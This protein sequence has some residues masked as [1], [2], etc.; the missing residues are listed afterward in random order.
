MMEVSLIEGRP[1]TKPFGSVPRHITG[2]PLPRKWRRPGVLDADWSLEKL[3][4]FWGANLVITL[5]QPNIICYHMLLFLVTCPTNFH[6]MYNS[7][8]SPLIN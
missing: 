3:S 6:F 2:L 5:W 4:G 8:R 7:V 1:S